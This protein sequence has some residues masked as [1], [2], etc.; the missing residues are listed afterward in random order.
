MGPASD[1]E[2]VTEVFTNPEWTTQ[3]TIWT[4]SPNISFYYDS[5]YIVTLSDQLYS[6][7]DP[8]TGLLYVPDLKAGDP[9]INLTAPYLPTHVTRLANLPPTSDL[10]TYLIAIAP[11][12][13]TECNTH[14][15]D[16]IP[17]ENVKGFLVFQG[18]GVFQPPTADDNVWNLGNTSADEWKSQYTFPVFAISPE[19]AEN[20]LNVSAQYSGNLTD[21]PNGHLLTESGFDSR[22]YA[23]LSLTI[24]PSKS[25]PLPSLWI[26]VLVV[27]GILLAIIFLTSVFLHLLQARRRNSLRRR[28]AN[29]EVDLEALGI[30]R[31]TVPQD[32]LD[33]MPLYTYGSGE[34]AKQESTT[35]IT[36]VVEESVVPNKLDSPPSSPPTSPSVSPAPARRARR[37]KPHVPTTLQQPTCAICLDDFV[38]AHGGTQGTIVRELPCQHIFHPEC[39]DNFLRESSSLCPMCKKTALPTGYCPRNI[40]NAMV[41]RERMVRRIRPRAEASGEEGGDG[42]DGGRRRPTNAL[43]RLSTWR[44]SNRLPSSTQGADPVELTERPPAATLTT[45]Q[46]TDGI[47][48]PPPVQPPSNSRRREWARR[49]AEAMLGRNQ[50]PADPE[51]E[52]E[53]ATPGWR[54]ALRSLFP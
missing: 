18:G 40:T 4:L 35:A 19:Q 28:V 13:T 3:R 54:K 34:P 38:A 7:N 43:A 23:R 49:R 37:A 47:S 36:T 2:I 17:L 15:L 16:A 44:S 1:Y 12:T 51:A 21:V 41:R 46:P 6:P 25:H 11:W 22:D 31:L 32:I 8:P 24:N 52:E 26:F 53:R 42:A 20:I 9:C 27:L 45:A 14:Y 33:E 50:A 39:V 29:G 10:P 30:K 5:S 48:T